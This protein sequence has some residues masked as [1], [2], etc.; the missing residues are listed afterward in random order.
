[1]DGRLRNAPVGHDSELF[2]AT[3]NRLYAMARPK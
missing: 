3:E 1:M 2:V